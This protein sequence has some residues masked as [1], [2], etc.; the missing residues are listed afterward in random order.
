M[1]IRNAKQGDALNFTKLLLMSAPYF[2]VL[3]GRKIQA[4]LQY[5]FC[6]HANLFSHRHSF[7]IEVDGEIAGMLLGYTWQEKNR[8]NIR[9]GFLLFRKLGISLISKYSV[10]LKFNQTVGRLNKADYY[11]SNI[12]IYPRYR[13]LGLGKRIMIQAEKNAKKMGAKNMVLDVEK[14]NLK[15]IGFYEKQGYKIIKNFQ[16][17]LQKDTPL[18]FCRMTKHTF[19]M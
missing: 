15:A 1:D 13:G 6:D 14:D 2:P 7:V 4:V 9:T 8:E 10:L 17:S 12:A 16:I 5:L 19:M 18:H 11:I 3:F